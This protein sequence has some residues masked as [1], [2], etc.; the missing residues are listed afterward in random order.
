VELYYDTRGSY[1][2]VMKALYRRMGVR[3]NHVQIYRWVDRLGMCC[4]DP[5][6]MA[7][8]L[9]PAWGECMGV[10]SKVIKISGG[11]FYL[12]LAVDLGSQD[13]IN[14]SLERHEDF[15]AYS[16]LLRE[17]KLQIG[18]TPRIIV[19]DLDPAWF[20]AIHHVYPGIPIQ[21]CVIHV[22]RIVDR[23]MPKRNRTIEQEELKLLIRRFLYASSLVEAYQ[24]LNEIMTRQD[25]WE[26]DAS[27]EAITTILTHHRI[28]TTHFQVPGSYRDN[29]ITES[30]IDKLE[31]KLKMIRGF[32]KIESARNSLRLAIT[33]YRFSPFLSSRNGNNGKSPLRLAGVDTSQIDWITYSQKHI[34]R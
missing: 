7:R 17:I 4:K 20:A 21:G 6:Q 13:V 23:V 31:M 2:R 11:E 3:P 16:A 8:E 27:R 22:E 25:E 24:N 19:T 32:K 1:R 10:D 9:H 14:Y 12:I 29:N 34:T 15:D 30:I 33:H 5:I 18:Y 28:L 26:D